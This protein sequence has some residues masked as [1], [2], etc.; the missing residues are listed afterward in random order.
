MPPTMRSAT[1]G[2]ANVG[3]EEQ[4]SVRL[5]TAAVGDPH[6]R[7]GCRPATDGQRHQECN[8]RA[9]LEAD[10]QLRCCA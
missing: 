8:P 5:R 9:D 1:R 3:P 2:P 10:R 7:F 6:G 4:A